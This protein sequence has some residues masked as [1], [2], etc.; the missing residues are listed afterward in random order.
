MHLKTEFM[1]FLSK[2]L[3]WMKLYGENAIPIIIIH[4]LS[5]MTSIVSDY[6]FETPQSNAREKEII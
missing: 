4:L 1:K 3:I 6:N 2:I 5:P